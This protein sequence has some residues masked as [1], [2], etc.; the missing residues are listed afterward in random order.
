MRPS[1]SDPPSAPVDARSVAFAK[2]TRPQ[3]GAIVDRE[4][5]FQRMDCAAGRNLIWISGPPGAG[6]TSLAA[7]FVENR[8]RRCLWYELDTDDADVA[9]FFH[10]FSHAAQRLDGSRIGALPVF[11]PGH[12]GK[13]AAFARAYFRQA[14]TRAKAPFSV[15]LDGMGP[16]PPDSAL[17]TV[18]E[19]VAAQLPPGAQLVITSRFDAPAGLARL[20]ASGQMVCLDARLLVLEPEELV[21]VATLRGQSL[22]DAQAQQLHQRTGGWAAGLVL[23]LEH[24]KLSGAFPDWPEQSTPRV[25]FDFLAGEIFEHFDPRMQGFLLKLSCLS[26]VTADLAQHLT[27]EAKAGRML[28]NLV[29]NNYFVTEVRWNEGRGFQIHPLMRDFLRNR[30]ALDLPE[31]LGAGH[32]RL[33]ARLLDEAGHAEDAA[34][35]LLQCRDW[36][37]LAALAARE[38]VAMLRQGRGETLAAWLEALPALSLAKAPALALA[39]AQSR[40]ATSPRIARRHFEMAH[41]AFAGFGDEVGKLH[42]ALGLVD[43][44]V[45]EFDDLAAL[46]PWIRELER[47]LLPGALSMGASERQ[48]ALQAIIRTG[49]LRGGASAPATDDKRLDLPVW[50]RAASALR[51]GDLG[52][53][54]A[55]LQAG[56]AEKDQSAADAVRR[57]IVAGIAAWL[58][59][60]PALA[61][62]RVQEG[63]RLVELGGLTGFDQLLQAL[64]AAQALGQSDIERARGHLQWFEAEATQLRRGDRAILSALRCWLFRLDGDLV[65]ATREGR[66]A[67]EL[68][69]EVGLVWLE[70]L[71]R[72]TLACLLAESQDYRGS[73]AQLRLAQ[74]LLP[75]GASPPL[76]FA[77]QLA[78][79]AVAMAQQH[80][81]QALDALVEALRMGSS[82]GLEYRPGWTPAGAAEL[83]VLA[84]RKGVETDYA[85]RWVRVGKLIP[86]VAP[87]RVSD[88]PWQIRIRT[89]GGFDIAIHDAAVEFSGKGPG[90]PAELLKLLVCLG[91]QGVRIFQLSD[92]MWPHMDADYAHKSFTAALHRL[93]RM[94]GDDDAVLLRDGRLSLNPDRVWTDT[95]ALDQVLGDFE[96]E[97]RMPGR[98][99]DPALYAS[100]REALGCYAGPF[101]PDEGDQPAFVACREQIRSRLLRCVARAARYWEELGEFDTATD[102][103]LQ[104]IQADNLFESPYR[105]L[106]LIHQR[107]GDTAAAREVYERLR[108]TLAMRLKTMP[109]AQTQAVFVSLDAAGSS[110]GS[111]LPR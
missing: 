103:H 58:G 31:V 30:A 18:V 13:L 20:Q 27:G 105:N 7:G 55:L 109:S 22:S 106:M 84:L 49:L 81:R 52:R 57:A 97:T 111:G 76:V 38:S 26:R 93:R 40:L 12:S 110:A 70:S 102:F 17:L 101:L 28:L 98:R 33:A 88:W 89:L 24:A 16:L 37:T 91:G 80:E 94:L 82:H 19:A 86:R 73:E 85:R 75:T 8:Q 44:L 35:L 25:V 79:V 72:C 83:C 56:D 46:D 54:H 63:L 15:V 4:R 47:M 1:K 53:A 36:E 6:K 10:Y 77:L 64:G 67:A 90:R 50:L 69:S 23:M 34:S 107:H 11:S 3:L 5:L 71:V 51:E 68:A 100:V 29:L 41:K 14:F 108:T 66:M 21:Q 59:G 32:L 99:P 60:Q 43:A 61:R 95:G 65:N 74:S 104:L 42:A 45:G 78:Q 96:G 9:T 87:L 92:A 2:T 62:E 48:M 39:Y